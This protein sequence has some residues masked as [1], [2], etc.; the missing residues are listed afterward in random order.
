MD[1]MRHAVS[2]HARC[3]ADRTR[4]LCGRGR[5]GEGGSTKVVAARSRKR[6]PKPV[7]PPHNCLLVLT[8]LRGYGSCQLRLIA[9]ATPSV[10]GHRDPSSMPKSLKS[11]RAC[12]LALAGTSKR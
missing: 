4:P 2:P 5:L 10:P 3:R 12:S 6:S 11:S 1:T 7:I 8:G 9:N